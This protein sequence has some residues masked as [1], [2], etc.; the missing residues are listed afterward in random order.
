MNIFSL[1]L[2]EF[3]KE[4]DKV[5]EGIS[6]EELLDEL[7]KY[8]LKTKGGKE[9]RK[10]KFRGKSEKTNEWV[11]GYYWTNELGNHFI[12]Q[13]VDL[14]GC[15]TISDTEVDKDTVGQYVSLKDKHGIKI[16]EGDIVKVKNIDYCIGKVVY[17]KEYLCYQIEVDEQVIFPVSVC[18]GDF[19]RLDIEVIGN[20]VDNRE[21]LKGG[22]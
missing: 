22:D 19:D 5:L 9:M 15:F 20:V 1:S 11:Y 14:N 21:L 4:I 6:P 2:E 3:E 13:T 8:G 12:R 10:I 16:Y 18:Y 7:K 17:D